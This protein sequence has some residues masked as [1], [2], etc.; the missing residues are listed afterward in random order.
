[1]L[2]TWHLELLQAK[3]P[4]GHDGTFAHL[5]M[6]LKWEHK[7]NLAQAEWHLE[8]IREQSK[9]QRNETLNFKCEMLE[10]LN[11]GGDEDWSYVTGPRKGLERY[12]IQLVIHAGEGS[13]GNIGWICHCNFYWF[14]TQQRITSLG[15]NGPW[16]FSG[17]QSQSH[18]F[19]SL[20]EIHQVSMS[21]GAIFPWLLRLQVWHPWTIDFTVD[22]WP[23]E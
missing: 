1:M 10:D 4:Q 12:T 22:P 9:R 8:R 18:T 16:H 7:E 2:P 19:I 17:W 11:R 13:A 5:Q 14:A 6:L 3:K 15:V 20:H 21:K 23:Y